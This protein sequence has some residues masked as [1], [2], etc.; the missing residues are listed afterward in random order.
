MSKVG[1][2]IKAESR[3]GFGTERKPEV[4]LKGK[5]LLLGSENIL[6]LIIVI[7]AQVCEYTKNP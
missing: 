2:S 5:R 3:L 6:K 4:T 1:K 7:V